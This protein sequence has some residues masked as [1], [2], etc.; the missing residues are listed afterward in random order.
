VTQPPAAFLLF[1]ERGRQLVCGHQMLLLQQL[2]QA[3]FF[4]TRHALPPH[5]FRLHIISIPHALD[6]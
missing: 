6:P 3:D 5:Q 2:T 1:I 4:G